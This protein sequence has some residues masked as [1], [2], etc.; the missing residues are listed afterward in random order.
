MVLRL[1]FGRIQ[2]V[3]IG[4]MSPSM[5]TK[6]IW[7]SSKEDNKVLSDAY[8]L[9]NIMATTMEKTHSDA[10]GFVTRISTSIVKTYLINSLVR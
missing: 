2:L 9:S 8:D 4:G 7:H 5:G 10:E 3:T 6:G 1:H